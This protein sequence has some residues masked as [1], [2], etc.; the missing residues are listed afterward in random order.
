MS[1]CSP[2]AL[3]TFRLIKDFYFTKRI[4]KDCIAIT[5]TIVLM[6]LEHKLKST[7]LAPLVISLIMPLDCLDSLFEK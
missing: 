5:L 7:R 3:R 4:T 6:F 1:K 2:D